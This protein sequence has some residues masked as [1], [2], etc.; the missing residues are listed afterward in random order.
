MKE[1]EIGGG[2]SVR[3]G[4]AGQRPGA[5]GAQRRRRNKPEGEEAT[6]KRAGK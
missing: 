6:E 2:G 5:A 4:K 1:H 3:D